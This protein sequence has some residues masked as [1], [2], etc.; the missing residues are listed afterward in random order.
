MH[1]QL[2][3][4]FHYP[5]QNMEDSNYTSHKNDITNCIQYLIVNIDAQSL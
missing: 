3:E 4:F 2:Q 1:T 5:I